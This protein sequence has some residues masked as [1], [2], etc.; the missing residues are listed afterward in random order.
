MLIT[1]QNSDLLTNKSR[2]TMFV[3]SAN[4]RKCID[5]LYKIFRPTTKTIKF[6]LSSKLKNKFYMPIKVEITFIGMFIFCP[7]FTPYSFYFPL[8]FETKGA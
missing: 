3:K 7:V 8:I 4:L 6:S 1:Y 5:F 2:I